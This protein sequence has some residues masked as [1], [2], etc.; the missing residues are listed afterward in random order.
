MCVGVE[1]EGARGIKGCGNLNHNI[2]CS[3]ILIILIIINNNLRA[4]KAAGYIGWKCSME[5]IAY[6]SV[7]SFYVDREQL[8]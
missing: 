4:K 5:N 6:G 2:R 3:L 7:I 1:V 8:H